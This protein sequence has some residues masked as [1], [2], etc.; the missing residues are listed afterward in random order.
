MK[1]IVFAYHD[2]GCAG[3]N[4]LLK[5]GFTISAIYTHA[6]TASENHFL[7]QWRELRLKIQSRFMLR[8]RLTIRCG[9]IAL[10]QQNL[11]LFSP[12]TTATCC[13]TTF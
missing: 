7:A 3:I 1:T 10:N 5:A 13:V 4:A 9:S 11:M 6:D 12:S 8:M 2:M